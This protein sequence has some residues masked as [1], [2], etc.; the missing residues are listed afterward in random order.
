M[1]RAIYQTKLKEVLAIDVD[2]VLFVDPGQ[3]F[4]TKQYVESGTLFLWDKLLDCQ[5]SFIFYNLSCKKSHFILPTVIYLGWPSWYPSYDE[6]WICDFIKRYHGH[7]LF[8]ETSLKDKYKSVSSVS[9]NRCGRLKNLSHRIR[10]QHTAESSLVL[11]DKSRH[12]N[13]IRILDELTNKYAEE[14]YSNTYGDKETYWLACEL[15][16]EPYAFNEWS[17]SH[18]APFSS[19]PQLISGASPLQFCSGNEF[20]E[21]GV[22]HYLPGEQRKIMSMN[23]CKQ[24]GC[25]L[26][27]IRKIRF[28]QRLS[29]SE[30]I[31]LFDNFLG[32]ENSTRGNLTKKNQTGSDDKYARQPPLGSKSSVDGRKS[33]GVL[34]YHKYWLDKIPCTEL[35]K[36]ETKVLQLRRLYMQDANKVYCEDKLLCQRKKKKK[37]N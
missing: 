14:V 12:T 10:T 34:T 17:A 21:P 23:E 7:L 13:A 19:A 36:A 2:T 8:K 9:L 16:Q 24:I 26:Y 6:S 18:W 30:T 27:G 4:E 25:M 1:A 28:S 3:I 37:G 31:D 32:S 15:A 5:Y 35:S 22:L 33:P 11:F 20:M 29:R